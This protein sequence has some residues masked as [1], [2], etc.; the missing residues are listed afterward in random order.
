[1]TLAVYILMGIVEGLAGGGG[2]ARAHVVHAR[3]SLFRCRF[4]VYYFVLS[5]LLF[6]WGG[7]FVSSV[8]S[9][10]RIAAF[11]VFTTCVYEW[12]LEEGGL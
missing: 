3:F 6:A 11:G 12:L 1:M 10:C 8:C 4:S 5:W 9:Q 2:S 7:W